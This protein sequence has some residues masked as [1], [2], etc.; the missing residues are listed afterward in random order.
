MTS[1]ANSKSSKKRLIIDL[2]IVG[3]LA[4]IFLL[5]YLDNKR[6]VIT[7]YEF[8]TTKLDNDIR[9]CQISDFHN[10]SWGNN[11]EKILNKIR[12]INPDYIVV[13][14]DLMDK[15]TTKVDVAMEFID[16]AK[17]IAPVYY[18]T[19]N[20]EAWK[21]ED[22]EILRQKLIDS[23][24]FV[25][26]N[27]G[28]QV[29]DEISIYG[30]MDPEM[31]NEPGISDS[32]L[33]DYGINKLDL[34]ES[35]FNIVLSH[36]PELYESYLNR[37]IDVVFSGHAHGGLIRIP[38]AGGVVAPNQ[39]LFPTYTSGS[40]S[41]GKTTMFISRGIGNSLTLLRVNNTP[42]IVVVDVHGKNK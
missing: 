25:L 6:L 34:S 40:F 27:Q 13:T 37:G 31:Y 1:T 8:E 36:R 3:V 23:G 15:L 12:D 19:G 18:C 2:V 38:F 10:S 33:I 7:N 42:E 35:D 39:G 29:T 14:G 5:I 4:L 32:S 41:D 26:E 11:Q 21:L 30:L 17:E 24:V 22:Y 20:H 16:G 28:V 9:I